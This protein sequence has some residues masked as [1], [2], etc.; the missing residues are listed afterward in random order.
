MMITVREFV[1]AVYSAALALWEGM[2]GV[3]LNE[4]DTEPAVGRFLERNPGMS[5]VA[6]DGE[7]RVVGAVLCGHD[8]RRG[9]LH[10]LAVARERRRGGA[11]RAML[12]HCFARLAAE[13]IPKCNIYLYAN[14][15]AGQAFWLHN[16]W[17]V[18]EE[19]RLVQKGVPAGS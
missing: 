16:G 8:G 3:G 19:L 5:A 10:H 4:S 11:A 1:A 2:E 18:R 9:Y 15:A 7:G 13:G 12:G 17:Q 14:N 6:V